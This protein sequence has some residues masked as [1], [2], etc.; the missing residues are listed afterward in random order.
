MKR[1][2]RPQNVLEIMLPPA[3][4][5]QPIVALVA[6]IQLQNRT[7]LL[8]HNFKLPPE[9]KKTN[10]KPKSKDLNWKP[11]EQIEGIYTKAAKQRSAKFK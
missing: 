1:S 4:L 11:L 10:E 8:L 6:E 7:R 3:F 2:E 5:L 9:T